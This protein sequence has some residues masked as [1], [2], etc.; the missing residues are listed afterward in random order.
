MKW[1]IAMLRES[2]GSRGRLVFFTVCIA[3]GVA[4]VVG[5]AAMAGTINEGLRAQARDLLAADMV[6][7]SR[8]PFDPAIEKMI[9]DAGADETTLTRE[10]ASMVAPVDEKGHTGK[11]SLALLKA[12]R[13]RFPFYGP[14]KLEPAGAL[15]DALERGVAVAPELGVEVGSK[16]RVGTKVFP[17]VAIVRDEPQQLGF[18]SMLGPRVFVKAEAL[19]DSGLL[20][21]GSRV[22]YRLLVRHKTEGLRQL[23]RQVKS[24]APGKEY[25]GV[26]TWRDGQPRFRRAIE[27]VERYMGLVALLSLILGGIGVAQIVRAWI[28]SRTPSIAILRCIGM[29]PKEILFLFLGQVSLLALVGSVLGAVGG[30][31][32]PLAFTDLASDLI[33]AEVLEGSLFQP[34]AVARG[35]VLGLAIALLFSLPPLTAVWRVSPA[36]VLRSEAVPLPTPRWI[37]VGSFAVLGAGILSTAWVQADSLLIGSIFTGGFFLLAAVLTAGARAVMYWTGH[38]PRGRLHP[39]LAQG[40]TALARPGAGTT[41]GIVALGLGVTVVASMAIVERDLS[42]GILTAIPKDAPTAFL[43]DVQPDQW[44]GVRGELEKQGATKVESAAIVMGRMRAING[45]GVNDIAK[46]RGGRARWVLTREQ[47]MAPLETLPADN[48]VVEGELWNEPGVWEVS[49][50]QRY[51]ADMGVKIG[52]TLK[53]DVQG[54]PMDFKLTSIRKV[55]WRS[56]SLNF[57][58]AVEPGSLE[59]APNF[60]F[61]A[62]RVPADNEQPLQDSLAS[63]YPNITMIRVRPILEQVVTLLEKLAIGVRALGA[64]TVFAGLAILAGAISAATLRRRREAALL[65]TLGA[66]RKGVGALFITEYGLLGGVAGLL[67]SLGALALAWGFLEGIADLEF[68]WPWATVPLAAVGAGVLAAACGILAS[69]HA[70]RAPPRESLRA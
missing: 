30:S 46:E 23:A 25:I 19:E 21:F 48:K 59:G 9:L 62:A 63:Q 28:A 32:M 51:A 6:V 56:F 54:V 8:R 35:I 58:V 68:G 12:V 38:I 20:G 15:S 70:L 18:M 11:S 65:K 10:F 45:R 69:L 50:E 66:T 1:L 29:R 41:G 61:A 55:E 53:I 31:L 37:Q 26:E 47:R 34:W 2:R 39:Y 67:G 52:D 33:R 16:L 43:V 60:R 49:L 13:G 7:G 64:F 3:I 40:L 24:E 22:R 17:V 27:R 36:R 42:S 5:V 14:M 57:F 4:A 44:E